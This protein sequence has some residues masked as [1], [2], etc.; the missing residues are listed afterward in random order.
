M[1]INQK[2]ILVKRKTAGQDPRVDEV[3]SGEESSQAVLYKKALEINLSKSKRPYVEACFLATADL[4]R[5]SALLEIPEDVLEAYKFF[6]YDLTGLDKLSR[7]DLLNVEDKQE[8]LLKI[9]AFSQGLDFIA[10]RL[11][12]RVNISPVDGL[13]E[14]FATCIMK[15][16]EA[17]FSGNAS[18]ESKEA[19]KWVKLSLDLARLLKAWVMDTEAAKADIEMALKE[20]V[21]DFEGFDSLDDYTTPSVKDPAPSAL[22]T[23]TES[24]SGSSNTSLA[25][26]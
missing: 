12:H 11:G 6:F 17:M 14:L 26:L 15:S 7:L 3:L 5:V 2:A 4:S 16:K 8:S 20:V 22:S 23:G 1:A 25:S 24:P 19:T 18:E 21:P 10:W 9:W 13:Q